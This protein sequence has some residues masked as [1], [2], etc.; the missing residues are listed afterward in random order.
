[1]NGIMCRYYEENVRAYSSIDAFWY[2]RRP[3]KNC[4]NIEQYSCIYMDLQQFQ[5]KN[6]YHVLVVEKKG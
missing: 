5:K 4:C 2:S 1:M 3:E 6:K